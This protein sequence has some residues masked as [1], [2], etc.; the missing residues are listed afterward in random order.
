[1]PL[2]RADNSRI[3]GWFLVVTLVLGSFGWFWVVIIWWLWIILGGC[4]S[5]WLVLGGFFF[6][7]SMVSEQEISFIISMHVKSFRR[8]YAISYH[9]LQTGSLVAIKFSSYKETSI[10]CSSFNHSIRSRLDGK[11]KS[12][13]YHA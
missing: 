9:T 3:L 1:M 12:E 11:I 7:V 8:I 5:F 2:K 10:E 13:I 6:L 4:G